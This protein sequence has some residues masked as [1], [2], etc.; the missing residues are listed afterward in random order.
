[1]KTI[2][3]LLLGIVLSS[4]LAFAQDDLYYYEGNYSGTNEKLIK[5]MLGRE[6]AKFGKDNIHMYPRLLQLG[7]CYVGQ[8]RLSEAEAVYKRVFDIQED[9]RKHDKYVSHD[10]IHG[11]M[12]VYRKQGRSADVAKLRAYEN[13]ITD[14]S[15]KDPRSY[16]PSQ[17]ELE[18]RY[19]EEQIWAKSRDHSES[20][21]K[22]IL[23]LQKFKDDPVDRAVGTASVLCKLGELHLR[24]GKTAQAEQEFLKAITVE[25]AGK[26]SDHEWEASSAL[27][28]MYAKQKKLTKERNARQRIVEIAC[29][30]QGDCSESVAEELG[31]LLTICEKQ[32][33]KIG[34]AKYCRQLLEVMERREGK[35]DPEVVRLRSKVA[36]LSAAAKH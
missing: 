30:S 34:A 2:L 20:D 6:E 26:R 3:S 5:I 22:K 27:A 24:Q 1:M 14:M 9:Y 29:Q 13:K 19:Q 33:D 4:Q 15:I 36:K 23:E 31:K 18:S 11:L 28:D 10:G 32:N 21:L 16:A 12:E 17:R 35:S 8:G 7:R 25:R